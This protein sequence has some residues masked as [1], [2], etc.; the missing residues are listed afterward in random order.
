MQGPPGSW[1]NLNCGSPSGEQA[2][3]PLFGTLLVL[4]KE[5][6]VLTA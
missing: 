1:Q 3:A 2:A 6:L 4:L 5:R